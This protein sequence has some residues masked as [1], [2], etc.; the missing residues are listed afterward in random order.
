MSEVKVNRKFP[1]R[2][3]MVQLST[4][5]TDSECLNALPS[6]TDRRQYHDISWSYCTQQYDWL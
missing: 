1:P 4:P 6:Q 3:T 2:N 5:Y